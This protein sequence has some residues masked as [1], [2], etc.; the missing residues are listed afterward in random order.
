MIKTLLI[1]TL[2]LLNIFSYSTQASDYKK[3][4]RWA[5]QIEDFIIDGDVK[6][7]NTG[8]NK[9]LII[10]TESSSKKT[11]NAVIILHGTGVHPDWPD[12]IQPLRTSLPDYQWNTLSIQ[13]PILSN[14]ASNA[15]YASIFNEI[16]PRIN[17]A[18]KFLKLKGNK[19]I[20]LIAHSLGSTMGA[21][22]L[23]NN[24]H[25][26]QAFISIG[27][28]GSSNFPSMNNINH[29][30]K[31]SL[32][33]LD[34]YGSNDLENILNSAKARAL[35]S[36]KNPSYSQIKVDDADHFFAGKNKQ[37][38]EVVSSWLNHL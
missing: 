30:K 9:T 1:S 38:I 4:L 8:K 32:P 22:F 17:A 7:L 36:T 29:L 35:A 24:K 11:T 33:V 14:D 37:L 13:M 6:W 25:N 16:S 3:E 21:Y 12:V 18:I 19:N 27:M 10:Y 15:D 34:L 5:E 28:P 31:I 2:I 23:A 26:I 20:V